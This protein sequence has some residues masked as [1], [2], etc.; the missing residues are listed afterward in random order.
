M[1]HVG[2]NTPVVPG[3]T[4]SEAIESI[5]RI[6]LTDP[7]VDI[8]YYDEP[9]FS[10]TVHDDNGNERPSQQKMVTEQVFRDLFQKSLFATERIRLAEIKGNMDILAFLN[11]TMVTEEIPDELFIRSMERLNKSMIELYHLHN[12]SWDRLREALTKKHLEHLMEYCAEEC[13]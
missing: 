2:I 11:E 9:T 6:A 7:K 4:Q 3:A 13:L 8:R 10:I 1:Y 5:I 12:K